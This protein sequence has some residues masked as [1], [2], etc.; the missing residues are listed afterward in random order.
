MKK[1]ASLDI[2]DETVYSLIVPHKPEDYMNPKNWAITQS[3][4]SVSDG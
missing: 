1:H 2:N 4:A 3:C